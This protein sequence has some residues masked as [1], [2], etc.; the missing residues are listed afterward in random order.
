M[1][2]NGGPRVSLF[3]SS[4]CSVVSLCER[5][6]NMWHPCGGASRQTQGIQMSSYTSE[7]LCSV[8]QT[9]KIS[10]VGLERS[11]RK[12]CKLT[13]ILCSG[14]CVQGILNFG[15]TSCI[16]VSCSEHLSNRFILWIH[17][18]TS[19]I[20]VARLLLLQNDLIVVLYMWCSRDPYGQCMVSE[21]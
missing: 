19:L 12:R 15:H 4:S 7:L 5:K 9:C 18:N 11:R 20:Q 2:V 10:S 21:A 17:M 3:W 14:S 6:K 1:V 8:I 13:L 16:R